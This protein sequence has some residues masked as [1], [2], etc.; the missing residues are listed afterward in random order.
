MAAPA[1]LPMTPP[2]TTGVG[3]P[4]ESSVP[5]ESDSL[6]G[7]LPPATPVPVPPTPPASSVPVGAME[8]VLRV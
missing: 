8:D 1:I 2:T 7:V 3:G 6:V 5:L 4:L